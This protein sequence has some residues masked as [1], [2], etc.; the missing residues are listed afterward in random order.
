MNNKPATHHSDLRGVNRLA[1]EGI[2]GIIGV[3]EGMHHAIA[4]VPG[5]H[6]GPATTGLAHFVF[7]SAVESAL[8][9]GNPALAL[10]FDPARQW[11][12]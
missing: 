3:V 8:G 11:I 12:G 9:H 10:T 7:H 1:I 5:T 4:T 6:R 2:S